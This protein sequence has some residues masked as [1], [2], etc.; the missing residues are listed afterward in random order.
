MSRERGYGDVEN[1]QQSKESP[2]ILALL[3]GLTL[4]EI[5]AFA[6]KPVRPE[7]DYREESAL[8]GGQLDP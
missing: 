8:S 7:L 2:A 1:A 3:S 4:A 6:T 5:D